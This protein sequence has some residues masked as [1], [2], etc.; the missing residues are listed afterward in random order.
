MEN[1]RKNRP[2]D[3]KIYKG[4]G[5]K[6]GCF[7][8]GMTPAHWPG[9]RKEE[10][11]VWIEAAATIGKNKYNWD[12]KITLALSANDIGVILTGFKQGSFDIYHDQDA[13]TEKQGTRPKKL[14]LTSGEKPGTF[15]LSLSLKKGKDTDRVSISL[16]PHEARILCTLL[17]HALPKILGW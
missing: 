11:A 12:D 4:M 9:A 1:E 6:Q 2:I 5:G 8:F 7:Q 16:A 14:T 17:E 13:Q 10:G 3:Y 15:Y